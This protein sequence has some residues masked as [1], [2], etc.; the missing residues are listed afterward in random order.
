M[1]ERQTKS[2]SPGKKTVEPKFNRVH[3]IKTDRGLF[4][5]SA[6][7]KAEIG[8]GKRPESK[9]AKADYKY[10]TLKEYLTLNCLIRIL[11]CSFE[12]CLLG[13]NPVIELTTINSL[14]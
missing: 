13:F 2:T 4:P 11:W 1:A 14:Q 10:Q 8:E 5:F 12:M 9:Q 6:L 3:F 7:R